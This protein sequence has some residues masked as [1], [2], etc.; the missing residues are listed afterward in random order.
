MDDELEAI[1]KRKLSEIQQQQMNSQDAALEESARKKEF[2]NFLKHFIYRKNSEVL[3]SKIYSFWTDNRSHCGLN[4]F[5]QGG[6]MDYGQGDGSKVLIH[7]SHE[8]KRA[9]AVEHGAKPGVGVRE[10]RGFHEAGFIL[11]GEKFHGVPVTGVN[12]LAGN[13][14]GGQ[15]YPPAHPV[16]KPVGFHGVHRFYDLDKPGDGVLAA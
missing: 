6:H 16:G 15:P 5:G 12:D 9:A 14:P 10:E 13:Q 1:R 8:N 7:G 3:P 2:E 4:G 11:K